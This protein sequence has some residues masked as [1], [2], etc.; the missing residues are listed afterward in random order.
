LFT[1]N[2]TGD[3]ETAASTRVNF[4]AGQLATGYTFKA[5]SAIVEE[6]NIGPQTLFID[7]FEKP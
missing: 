2:F 3:L 1:A 5:S 6:E 7:S 4:T